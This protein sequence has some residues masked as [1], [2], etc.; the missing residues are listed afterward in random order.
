ML[1]RERSLRGP[2]RRIVTERIRENGAYIEDLTFAADGRL[3]LLTSR[4]P[5]GY[6]FRR[7][8]RYDEDGREI[9]PNRRI[10]R[11]DDG[12]WTETQTL[13][14]DTWSMD[15][16]HGL[17]FGTD[18]AGLAETSFDSHGLPLRTLF[19]SDQQ[20]EVSIIQ[21]RCDPAG[22]IVEA[23]Q[24]SAGTEQFRAVFQYDANGLILEQKVFF[25]EQLTHRTSCAYNEHGDKSRETIEDGG[26]AY[27]HEFEYEYD[28]RGNWTRQVVHHSLGTDEVRRKITYYD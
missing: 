21:Y 4:T 10:S 20:E 16:L 17:A 5:D 3:V 6:E 27:S 18:G 7:E 25:A 2:I 19:R 24:Y 23:G 12:S 1:A 22:R 14:A 28:A 11:H 26:A 8:A 9:G 13:A 15:L